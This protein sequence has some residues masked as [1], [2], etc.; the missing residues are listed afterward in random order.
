[1]KII[2][3]NHKW[4]H[5][6]DSTDPPV[7]AIY[8]V[9]SFF[10]RVKSKVSIDRKNPYLLLRKRVITRPACSPAPLKIIAQE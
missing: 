9:S 2:V 6:C 8:Q 1:M 4:Q 3:G 5:L 10:Q 7:R